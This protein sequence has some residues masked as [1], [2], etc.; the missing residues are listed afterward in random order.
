MAF[1][2]EQAGKASDGFGSIMEYSTR[3]TSAC[4]FG[5]YNMVEAEEF[6]HNARVK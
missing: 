6:M 2:V 4:S 5:S 1:I 3:I